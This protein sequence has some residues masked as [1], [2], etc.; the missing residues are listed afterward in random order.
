M[1]IWNQ[2]QQFLSQPQAGQGS[3]TMSKRAAAEPGQ[4]AGPITRDNWISP[5]YNL[6][7]P[8][9]GTERKTWLA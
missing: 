8:S 9:H 4:S 6:L 1:A 2:L 7:R 5:E 3:A